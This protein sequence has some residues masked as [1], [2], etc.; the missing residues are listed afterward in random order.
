MTIC[1]FAACTTPAQHQAGDWVFCDR[2]LTAHR[3]ITFQDDGQGHVTA[4]PLVQ[5]LLAERFRSGTVRTDRPRPRLRG[6]IW[7]V[8]RELDTT[9][10]AA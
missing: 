1:A 5:K 8:I 9:E 6:D 10:A 4:S 7:A 2:H 3:D